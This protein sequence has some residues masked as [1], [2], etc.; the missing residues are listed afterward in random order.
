MESRILLNGRSVSRGFASNVAVQTVARWLSFGAVCIS[1]LGC[2]AP[3]QPAKQDLPTWPA[4]PKSPI[5]KAEAERIALNNIRTM[6]GDPSKCE[7]IGSLLDKGVWYVMV[8]VIPS[9]VGSHTTYMISS[10][11]GT[12]IGCEGGL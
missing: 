10:K 9:M 1:F 2:T 6:G 5:S 12:V 8:R 11:D 4:A 7:V 3:S